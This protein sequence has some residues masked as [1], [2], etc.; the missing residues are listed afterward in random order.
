[1]LSTRCQ[2]PRGSNAHRSVHQTIEHDTKQNK[3]DIT[4]QKRHV[5]C[6]QSKHAQMQLEF[7]RTASATISVAAAVMGRSYG[8]SCTLPIIYIVYGYTRLFLPVFT[9]RLMNGVGSSCTLPTIY[10]AYGYARLFHPSPLPP[11]IFTKRL[12]NG[13]RA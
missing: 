9:K 3:Q 12:M 13:V 2:G 10:I 1:M 11:P 7:N 5:P 8:Y 6:A 4:K